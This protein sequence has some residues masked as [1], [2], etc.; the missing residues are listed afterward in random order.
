[1]PERDQKVVDAL[2]KALS[3]VDDADKARDA[4][5]KSPYRLL[6][7]K[8]AAEVEYA[9]LRISI[10]HGLSDY[11]PGKS[12]DIREDDP[13][14]SLEAVRALLREA[15]M[16]FEKDPRRA[17]AAVRGAVTVLRRTQASVERP[18]RSVGRSRSLPKKE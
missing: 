16:L 1:M 10:T 8:S 12:K 4:G 15:Q 18:Q 5:D 17:Y 7:W 2:A 3:L 14:N 11:D 9:A 13:Q 6:L